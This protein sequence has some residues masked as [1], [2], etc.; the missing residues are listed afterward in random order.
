M[1]I[2]GLV[3]GTVQGSPATRTTSKGR[4]WVTLTV[5]AQGGE[6]SA[7]V[8]V[9]VFDPD[10]VEVAGG[11]SEGESVAAQGRLEL[12]AWTGRDGTERTGLSI[13]AS[14]LMRLEKAERRKRAPKPSPNAAQQDIPGADP[15]G[16]DA[17]N[18]DDVLPPARH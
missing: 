2:F 13:T 17:G 5:K 9:A 12:R 18:L 1:S 10:L 6:G 11:L 15:F 16:L 7:F 8:S 14:Q 4:P 3:S